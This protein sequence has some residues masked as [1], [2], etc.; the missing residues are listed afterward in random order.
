MPYGAI[1]YPF[2]IRASYFTE[3]PLRTAYLSG[4]MVW[5]FN[6]K[7]I[8]GGKKKSKDW[9]KLIIKNYV[10]SWTQHG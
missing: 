2:S 10:Q 4:L 1:I 8:I 7:E 9:I 5:S 3:H 6:I